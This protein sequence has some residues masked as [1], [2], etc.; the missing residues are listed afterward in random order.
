[1]SE[2]AL[3]FLEVTDLDTLTR[4]QMDRRNAYWGSRTPNERLQEM[5]RLNRAKWGDEVF[6]RGVD[7]SKIEVVDRKTGKVIKTIY[8]TL[9]M[10][11]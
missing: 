8:N 4:E 2:E 9:K 5:M 7:K 11:E 1:M 3:S 10:A 6:D